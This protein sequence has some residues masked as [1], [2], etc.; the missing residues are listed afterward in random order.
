MFGIDLDLELRHKTSQLLG[1]LHSDHRPAMLNRDR[2]DLLQ[3]ARA[4]STAT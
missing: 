2:P 4:V 1:G 3:R